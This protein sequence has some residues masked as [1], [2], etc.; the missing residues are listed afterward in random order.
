MFDDIGKKIMAL[1]K[2]T[3]VLGIIASVIIAILLF[4]QASELSDYYAS[5]AQS[6][7]NTTAWGVL[8]GGS[9]GS[10]VG[11]F[12]LY[13]FGQLVDDTADIKRHLLAHPLTDRSTSGK[14]N[15]SEPRPSDYSDLPKL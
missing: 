15:T 6:A 13:A 3:A 12:A 8:I 9:F 2:A 4:V 7:L 1:A 14:T 10:W 5:D 11:S